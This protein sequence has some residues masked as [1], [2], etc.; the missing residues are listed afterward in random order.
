MVVAVAAMQVTSCGRS[1]LPPTA[2]A[3]EI[4]GTYV[5]RTSS[6]ADEHA[7]EGIVI[8]LF[9]EEFF[10]GTLLK[11]PPRPLATSITDGRGVF[12]FTGIRPG[13]Y[14]VAP[15]DASA[16]GTGVWA[17]VES[18]HGAVVALSGCSDCPPPA[19]A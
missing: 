10:P 15:I 6:G 13:R 19:S 11:D 17:V 9:D 4:A 18:S 2:A 16:V 3:G 1:A 5:Q 8:G 14:F 7:V 12:R